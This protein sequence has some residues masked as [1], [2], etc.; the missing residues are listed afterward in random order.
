MT[1]DGKRTTHGRP[2]LLM[3]YDIVF[4][5]HHP[6]TWRFLRNTATSPY[7][8]RRQ[9]YVFLGVERV[10]HVIILSV[11]AVL[12]PTYE[13]ECKRDMLSRTQLTTVVPCCIVDPVSHTAHGL[14]YN[15]YLGGGGARQSSV[16]ISNSNKLDSSPFTY[17]NI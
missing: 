17:L 10:V 2:L 8:V 4:R 14:Y 11:T 9:I 13:L 3:R 6:S 1:M 16:D 15:S 7:P 5:V 12:H